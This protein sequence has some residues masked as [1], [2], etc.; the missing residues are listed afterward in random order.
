MRSNSLN[1]F[2]SRDAV[3]VARDLIGWH[4][5]VDGVGGRIVETEAYRPDDEASHAFRGP[6]PR[7]MAMF[8]PAGHVYIY[9]S[10]GIHWCINF[11]CLPGSAVLIRAIEPESGI[12]TMIARR[13][14]GNIA[15]LCSGPGKLSQ[16]MGIDIGLDGRS[17][18]QPPFEVAEAASVPVAT[19]QRIGITRNIEAP[20]RFGALGSR[21]LSRKFP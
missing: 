17:L 5:S 13:G 2:F 14:T 20:W 12:E 15:Q 9:R 7:N 8:G 16:A 19:G 6:R 4:F 10:Y 21:F 18:D 3:V 1:A 11:V